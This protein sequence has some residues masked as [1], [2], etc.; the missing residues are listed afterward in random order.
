MTRALRLAAIFAAAALPAVADTVVATVVI[1]AG[2]IVTA[3][4]L[5]FSP[6]ESAGAVSDPRDV[7]GME[8]RLTLYPA[9]P[10]RAQDVGLPTVVDRNEPVSLSY[11]TGGLRITAE[12]RALSRAG[13]GE[14]VRVMNMASRATVMGIATAPGQVEVR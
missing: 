8:A 10:I 4:Q 14:P 2:T 3:D 5:A 7:I 1:P 11:V 9:R 6:N 12:G 13:A